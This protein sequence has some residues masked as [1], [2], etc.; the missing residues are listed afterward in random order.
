MDRRILIP[1]A[2][3]LVLAISSLVAAGCARHRQAVAT[4]TAPVIGGPF[5]L[6]DQDG[7]P[8][9]DKD[10]QG[11][12]SVVFFGFTYCPDV[13]PTTLAKLAEWMKALGPDADR[14]NVVFITID[15]ARDTPAQLKRYLASFDPRFRGFTGSD[16]AIAA[17]AHEYD[18]YVQKVPLPGGGYTMDHSTGV[19]LLDRKGRFAEAL[20]TDETDQEA[21]AALRRVQES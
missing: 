6:V 14:F 12:P 18:V 11:K 10:L 4:S 17:A 2:A 8:V 16:Q 5:H 3:V 13:C 20:S 15:P 1:A 21:T 9:S 19:Y 7:H